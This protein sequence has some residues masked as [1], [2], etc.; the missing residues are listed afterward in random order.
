M[1]GA[2]DGGMLQTLGRGLSEL[3]YPTDADCVLCGAQARVSPGTG[4]CENCWHTMA[5]AQPFDAPGLVWAG[6]AV[7]H[8]GGAKALVHKLK[9]SG[10]QYLA[11]GMGRKM[12]DA[13]RQTG[14]PLP[15][16]LV[17]VPL[18]NKRLRERGYNQADLLC[19]SMG[20]S[21]QIPVIPMLTRVKETDR[22]ATL[23][24]DERHKN[25]INAF[26]VLSSHAFIDSNILIVDDVITTASTVCSCAQVLA[27]VGIQRIATMAFAYRPYTNKNGDKK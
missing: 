1:G 2:G 19:Q 22:Q 3:I 10:A 6:A 18:G 23:G 27:A 13:Y 11:Y 5:L 7:D 15:K 25:T 16:A 24:R 20:D 26:A 12:A 14:R 9:F 8:D 21:L 17:P 4:V